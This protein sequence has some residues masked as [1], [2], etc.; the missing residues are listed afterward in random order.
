MN[1][2]NLLLFAFDKS[3]DDCFVQENDADFT[4]PLFWM[5]MFLNVLSAE[6]RILDLEFMV[7]IATSQGCIEDLCTFFK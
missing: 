2:Q 6:T 4:G 7:D 1:T 5:V 3:N